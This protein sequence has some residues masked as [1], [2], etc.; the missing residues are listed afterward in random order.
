MGI[1]TTLCGV[2]SCTAEDAENNFEIVRSFDYQST[3]WP[4]RNCFGAPR[5]GYQVSV[6][7]I[8]D[9]IKCESDERMV[10]LRHFE[11]LL[12]QLQFIETDVFLICESGPLIRALYHEKSTDQRVLYRMEMN[13]LQEDEIGEPRWYE[14]K[15]PESFRDD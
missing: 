1:S 7:P 8:T 14:V 13:V 6:I 11:I 5:K 12:F 2:I 15:D 3:W 9:E 10:W 4:F